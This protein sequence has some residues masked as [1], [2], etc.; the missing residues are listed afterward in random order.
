MLKRWIL[1]LIILALASAAVMAESEVRPRDL[2]GC[3]AESI[4]VT[5]LRNPLIIQKL[6]WNHIPQLKTSRLSKAS[7][8]IMFALPW[9][10]RHSS[11]TMIQVN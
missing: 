10:L 9:S 4:S 11:I 6:I 3:V 8:L 1:A 5:G 7:A 2:L